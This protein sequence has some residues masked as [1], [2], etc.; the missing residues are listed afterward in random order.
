MGVGNG[1]DISNLMGTLESLFILGQREL[2]KTGKDIWFIA[3]VIECDMAIYRVENTF[4]TLVTIAH[5]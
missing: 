4:I 5:V 3:L 2:K 1:R